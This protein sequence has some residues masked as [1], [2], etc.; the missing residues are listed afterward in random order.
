MLQSKQLLAA[1]LAVDEPDPSLTVGGVNTLPDGG[2]QTSS[3]GETGG[4]GEDIEYKTSTLRRRRKSSATSTKKEASESEM[5]R[6]SS[7]RRSW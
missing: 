6:G 2:A 3:T 4:E 5:R 1:T 7:K